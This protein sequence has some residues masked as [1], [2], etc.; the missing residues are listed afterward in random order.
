MEQVH[1]EWLQEH[2]E[3]SQEN[4]PMLKQ[5]MKCDPLIRRQHLWGNSLNLNLGP[6]LS[7]QIFHRMLLRNDSRNFLSRSFLHN[8]LGGKVNIQ[9][10]CG[11]LLRLA[12]H[13]EV[14]ETR[15]IITDQFS[16][17]FPPPLGSLLCYFFSPRR[18]PL[19]FVYVETLFFFVFRLWFLTGQHRRKC[20]IKRANGA[21][22]AGGDGEEKEKEK[23]KRNTGRNNS[24]IFISTI[25]NGIHHSATGNSL[26]FSRSSLHHQLLRFEL[27]TGSISDW[28]GVGREPSFSLSFSLSLLP[29]FFQVHLTCYALS[30]KSKVLFN[31]SL[32][33]QNAS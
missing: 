16:S 20:T 27:E 33:D 8:E 17:L 31:Q 5:F 24:M 19:L 1:M 3:L 15:R 9:G 28:S 12:Q 14:V 13:R 10:E 22:G 30:S 2:M 7:S 4:H 23:K 26:Q 29:S 21:R 32:F 18:Y 25:C 11:A 6:K